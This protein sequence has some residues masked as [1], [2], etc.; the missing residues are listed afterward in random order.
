VI[1][2][3]TSICDHGKRRHLCAICYHNTSQIV[4]PKPVRNIPFKL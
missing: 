3:G 1:C 2:K 4:V